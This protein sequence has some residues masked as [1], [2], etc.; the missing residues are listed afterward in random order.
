MD[1]VW[2]PNVRNNSAKHNWALSFTCPHCDH[3]T[4]TPITVYGKHVAV[5]CDKCNKFIKYATR[6]EKRFM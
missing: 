5:Y 4:A 2:E 3:V 6:T 1:K